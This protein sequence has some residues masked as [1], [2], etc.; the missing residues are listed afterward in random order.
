MKTINSEFVAKEGVSNV[1]EEYT[2][3][4]DRTPNTFAHGAENL[5]AAF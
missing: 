3:V 5:V 1:Q 2:E 4:S